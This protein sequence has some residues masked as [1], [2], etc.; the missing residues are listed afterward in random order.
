MQG[1]EMPIGKE[2][3]ILYFMFLVSSH[4]IYNFRTKA[5]LHGASV[6]SRSHV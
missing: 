2:N 1:V 6:A 5:A 3:H 4:G